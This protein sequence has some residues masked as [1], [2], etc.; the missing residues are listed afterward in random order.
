MCA[1]IPLSSSVPS[2]R[3]LGPALFVYS[4]VVF[5]MLLKYHAVLRIDHAGFAAFM[6]FLVSCSL[7]CVVW[8]RDDLGSELGL[9]AL[10]VTLISAWVSDTGAYFSGYFFGKHKLCPTISPKKT[11]EGAVGGMLS[12][13]VLMLIYC[14]VLQFAFGFQLRQF[15]VRTIG[16]RIQHQHLIFVKSI[17]FFC[18]HHKKCVT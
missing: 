7:S 15:K 13:V 6:S 14:L 17:K 5:C 1:A 9:Y 18:S 10:S 16:L 11:I 4:F 12:S 2:L 8:L 3:L